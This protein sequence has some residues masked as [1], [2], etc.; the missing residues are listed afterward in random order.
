[1]Q[2]IGA[3]IDYGLRTGSLIEMTTANGDVFITNNVATE[4]LKLFPVTFTPVNEVVIYAHDNDYLEGDSL[5]IL[6][7]M[8]KIKDAVDIGYLETGNRFE[9]RR[10]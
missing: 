4:F 8:N 1:M 3:T 7:F 6:N 10:R 9:I 5:D 2:E